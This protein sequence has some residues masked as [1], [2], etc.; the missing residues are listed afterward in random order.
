MFQ[1]PPEEYNA[2]ARVGTLQ[3]HLENVEQRSNEGPRSDR[4]FTEG[5]LRF[6]DAAML[7]RDRW[8]HICRGALAML[9]HTSIFTKTIATAIP[10]RLSQVKTNEK[11]VPRTL[12]TL[13]NPQ[14]FISR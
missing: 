6:R 4:E 12:S 1:S 13:R 2:S 3:I 14:Q 10:R 7:D 11:L 9:T 5:N 8:P